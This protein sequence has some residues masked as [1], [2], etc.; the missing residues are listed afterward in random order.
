MIG[1]SSS[2]VQDTQAEY[3]LPHAC[4]LL[5][6]MCPPFPANFEY[7]DNSPSPFKKCEIQENVHFTV[8]V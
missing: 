7:P 3:L 8:V 2:A 5:Q 6:V 4:S 1:S